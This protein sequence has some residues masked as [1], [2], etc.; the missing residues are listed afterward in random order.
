MINAILGIAT[1]LGGVAAIA[2]FVEKWLEP[3]RHVRER[4]A[5]LALWEGPGHGRASDRKQLL[6][7]VLADQDRS[8]HHVG[9]FGL[10]SV[11]ASDRAYYTKNEPLNLKPRLWHTGVVVD[12]ILDLPQSSHTRRAISRSRVGMERLLVDGWVEVGMGARPQ[13]LPSTRRGPEG[14]VSYRHTIRA[15]SVLLSVDPGSTHVR[16]FAEWIVD[17]GDEA[18]VDNGGW[19]QCRTEFRDE[20]MWASAYAVKFLGQLL[21]VVPPWLTPSALQDI[22][23]RQIR[24]AEWLSQQWLTNQW[25]YGEARSQDN[26]PLIL[27]EVA[28]VLRRLDPQ[29]VGNVLSW[30]V[31]RLTP[32]GHPNGELLDDLSIAGPAGT[33]ARLAYGLFRSDA[34]GL[35]PEIAALVDYAWRE[36]AAK[37]DSAE[38]AMLLDMMGP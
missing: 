33:P 20:D 37:L 16:H 6:A 4:K 17:H 7:F 22:E 11:R 15:T 3:I 32:N 18:Q 10:S 8:G 36:R 31:E 23:R 21:A 28:P 12:V 13:M 24:T 29:T 2:Y 26:A 34:S 14:V 27:A 1:A 19:R 25:S 35:K 38:A 5:H 9:Q 30:L